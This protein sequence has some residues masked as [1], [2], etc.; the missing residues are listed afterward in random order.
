MVQLRG[1]S[2]IAD[3]RPGVV[4]A[5]GAAAR[6]IW[7]HAPPRNFL[8]LDALRSIL[9]H[10]WEISHNGRASVQTAI[11]AANLLRYAERS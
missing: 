6:G 2:R 10:F 8:T 4:H 5:K 1:G 11:A 3:S 9:V 7:G